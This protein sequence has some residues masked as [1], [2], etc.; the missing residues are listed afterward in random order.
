MDFDDNSLLSELFG[1]HDRNLARIEQRLDVSLS[2]RGNRVAI[3]GDPSAQAAAKIVLEDLYARLKKGH[4]MGNGEVD[5]AIRM[6]E[7]AATGRGP[8]LSVASEE[9]MIRTPRR[10]LTPRSPTQASYIQNLRSSE[11]TFG[12]GPAGTGKTF[13]AVA[14]AIEALMDGAV[15]RIILSRPA[16]EAGERLGFLPGDMRDKIDPYLRPLYDALNYMMPGDQVVRLMESGE[17]EVAPVA[18]MRGRTLTNAYII[19]DEAQNT[20][21]VQMKMLLT[22]LGEGSRMVVNGDLSQIDLPRGTRSGLAHAADVLQGVKGVK[23]TRFGEEDIVR[24]DLVTRIVH[25]YGV[26]DKAQGE[27]DEYGLDRTLSRK[28]IDGKDDA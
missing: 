17:I 22:R 26:F 23:F 21:T 24:H 28:G 27:P 8:K 2:S 1:E 14:V 4:E 19:V 20:T 9:Y 10:S 25:A 18:F 3:I 15:Q 13:L 6:A 5:A 7:A 11:L 12:L 16:V